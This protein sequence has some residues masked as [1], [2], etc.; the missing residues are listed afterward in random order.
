MM[1]HLPILVILLPLCGIL[2]CPLLSWIRASWGKRA[3]MCGLLGALICA[4]TQLAQVVQSGEAI[5]YWM[6]GWMPP[7]GIEFVIDGVNGA[8]VVLV[9]VISFLTALYSS[10]FQPL[11]GRKWFQTAGYYVLIGFLAVGLLGMAS[12]GDA[13]NLYVFMEITALSGYGLI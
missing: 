10:P 12:T 13:F 7:F 6:G 2:L 9:A 5:H 11:D 4:V 8:V 3:V 1:E